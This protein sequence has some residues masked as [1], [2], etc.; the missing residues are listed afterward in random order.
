MSTESASAASPP[1]ARPGVAARLLLLLIEA[2]RVTLSPLLGG[3]CRFVPSCSVY[4]EEAIRRHGARRG[5]AGSPSGACSAAIRSTAAAS[6]PSLR[7]TIDGR[8]PSA[9]RRRA[10]APGP[11]RLPAPV[12]AAPAPAAGRPPRPAPP[13][14]APAAAGPTPPGRGLAAAAAPAPARRAVGRRSPTSGSA[15]WRWRRR[16]RPSPSRTGGALCP[17]SSSA[18]KDAAGAP[19]GDGARRVPGR[20]AAAGPRDRATPTSTRACARRSSGPPRRR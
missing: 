10:V 14:S 12:S 19:G 5:A 13:R 6:T 20:A 15:G 16:G 2:Y 1:D 11:D 17:G 9:A 3:F 18:F 8:T 4:A 7:K